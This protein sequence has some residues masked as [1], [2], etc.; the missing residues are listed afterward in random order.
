MLTRAQPGTRGGRAAESPATVL[1]LDA[2]LAVLDQMR[3]YRLVG[4]HRSFHI[5]ALHAAVERVLAR[6]VPLADL[7]A[8][9]GSH[10]D[11]EEAHARHGADVDNHPAPAALAR[12]E[13]PG[14]VFLFP[15]RDGRTLA[16]AGGSQPA[17]EASAPAP[18]TAEFSLPRFLPPLFQAVA[19][20]GMEPADVERVSCALNGGAADTPAS[21]P[22]Q[23]PSRKRPASSG[24][25]PP[26]PTKRRSP[27]LLPGAGGASEQ[28]DAA[29]RAAVAAALLAPMKGAAVRRG[30]ELG[31]EGSSEDEEDPLFSARFG[32]CDPTKP[33]GPGAVRHSETRRQIKAARR[34]LRLA[35]AQS[36]Q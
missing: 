19:L 6:E 17:P 36:A 21:S 1:P 14:D 2:E 12:A 32:A 9:L 8:Y 24:A 31:A 13:G 10:F 15:T 3:H 5:I 34:Q 23:T 4:L 22:P 26:A 11:L 27:V 30:C 25:L 18:P 7:V 33:G 20:E 28:P 35:A 16:S 29:H